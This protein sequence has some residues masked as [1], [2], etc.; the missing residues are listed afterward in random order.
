MRSV[1]TFLKS[2]AVLIVSGVAAAV[3]CFFV[4]PSAAYLS[5]INVRVLAL[6][7]CLMCVVA[8][9]KDAGAFNVLSRLLLRKVRS[10]RGLA[11]FLVLLSFLLSMFLTNDVSLITLV[12]FTLLVF[13]ELEAERE[14]LLTLV[15]ETVAA[16]LGSMLMPF[17]NP[18]NLFLF[19]RYEFSLPEFLAL[20][21]PCTILSLVLVSAATLL[22]RRRTIAVAHLAGQSSWMDA[23]AFALYAALFVLCVLS[24]ARLLDYRVLFVI[25]VAVLLVYRRRILLRADYALLATFV[26]FFVFVGNMGNIP[27]VRSCIRSF[28]QGHELEA[29]VLASQ[30]VSNVPAALLLAGFTENG[31]ALVLGTNIGGLGT[32]I[33]SMAS[34]ITFRFYA[35]ARPRSTKRYLL[36]F[37]LVNIV[38]LLALYIFSLAAYK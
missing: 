7:F 26:F 12:P 23:K 21:L 6:L 2:Q 34:L 16:N 22:V 25:V 1:K 5:Y 31:R 30:F 13:A 32:L 19:A 15:L 3:S 36:V 37:T 10:T 11:L 27:A 17:G 29:A 35:A 8:G 14:L 9:M 24:V 18:Q 20:M 28:M 38:F 33:A 4:P